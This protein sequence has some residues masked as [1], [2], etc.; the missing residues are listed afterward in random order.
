MKKDL[1]KKKLKI[2]K[3]MES[4]N[5]K[6]KNFKE[7]ELDT[8]VLQDD[9]TQKEANII[10]E[11]QKK[12]PVLQDDNENW[13]NARDL[14]EQ[15]GVGKVFANWIKGRIEKYDFEENVDYI[16]RLSNLESK[17]HGEQNA[18]DYKIIDLPKKENQTSGRGGDRKSV[19]YS[20]TVTMAKELSMVENNEL[21]RLSRK[22]FIAIEHAYLIRKEWNYDRADSLVCYSG[23]QRAFMNPSNRHQLLKGLPDWANNNIQIADFAAINNAIIGMTA[24]EF[25]NVMGLKPKESIRNAFTE[26]QLEYVAELERFDAD[27]ISIHKVFDWEDRNKRIFEKY[28]FL[29]KE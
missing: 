8:Y 5:I 22:Y 28:K 19:D 26:Q 17:S 18:I 15:L 2:E 7:D 27:L 6:R 13:I 10:M 23:L 1:T 24:K 4:T 11:Y 29:E 12:L 9:I 3:R 21:G 14:H 20:I 16:T 25:R